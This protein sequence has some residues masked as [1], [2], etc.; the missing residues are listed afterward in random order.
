M[1]HY[2]AIKLFH[3][4]KKNEATGILSPRLDFLT[5]QN[6]CRTLPFLLRYFLRYFFLRDFLFCWH[7]TTSLR[8][9]MV[10]Q[11]DGISPALYLYTEQACRY[12]K[13]LFY[14]YPVFC[15]FTYGNSSNHTY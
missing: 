14:S 2:K 5:L 1:L 3:R 10:E 7:F 15:C 11:Q 13:N 8:K 4:D 9:E 6:K 12:Q